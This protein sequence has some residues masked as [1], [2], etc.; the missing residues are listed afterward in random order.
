[1]RAA[2]T[3]RMVGKKKYRKKRGKVS[4]GQPP[5]WA[6]AAS[7]VNCFYWENVWKVRNKWVLP[8]KYN[9]HG[10]DMFQQTLKI[11]TVF[12]R[13]MGR[14]LV[15]HDESV[16]KFWIRHLK[17]HL[18]LQRK[19]SGFTRNPYRS[20]RLWAGTRSAFLSQ[21]GPL[22]LKTSCF[23]YCLHLTLLTVTEQLVKW[24]W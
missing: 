16:Q 11:V 23:C 2:D 3:E 4:S 17:K 22:W 7:T 13:V 10:L 15:E 8:R 19:S 5:L 1:M 20:H 14:E 24:R 6:T 9:V 18:T 21:C 12:C